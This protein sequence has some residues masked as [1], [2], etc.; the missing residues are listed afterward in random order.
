MKLLLLAAIIVAAIIVDA[1]ATRL[2]HKLFGHH[3]L[4]FVS[5]NHTRTV[6]SP[7]ISTSSPGHWS[8]NHH[9]LWLLRVPMF[10]TL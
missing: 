4:S 8:G 5:S 1:D 9:F 7:L 3:G 2:K 6:L 10:V